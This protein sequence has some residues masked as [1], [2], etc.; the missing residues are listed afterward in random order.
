MHGETWAWDGRQLGML[1]EPRPGADPLAGR[2]A[3]RIPRAARVVLYGGHQVVDESLP[4]AL[5]DTWVW[6]D[7]RSWTDRA[8]RRRARSRS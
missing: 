1:A 5:G 7:G 2:D 8:G 3:C 6:A 4:P